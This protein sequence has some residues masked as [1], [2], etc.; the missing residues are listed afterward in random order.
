MGNIRWEGHEHAR[1][2]WDVERV[3][4]VQPQR[5]DLTAAASRREKDD[6]GDTPGK[7]IVQAG[8]AV[9]AVEAAVFVPKE[10]RPLFARQRYAEELRDLRTDGVD[11][12]LYLL[13]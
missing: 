1:P 7:A 3:G 11:V 8:I 9:E 5:P 13:D 2:W 12:A 6:D 4:R 10:P